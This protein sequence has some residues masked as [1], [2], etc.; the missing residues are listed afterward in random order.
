MIRPGLPD[1]LKP[2]ASLAI[3]IFAGKLPFEPNEDRVVNALAMILFGNGY[4]RVAESDG[5][6]VGFLVGNITVAGMWSNDL[7]GIEA[8][9]GIHPDHRSFRLARTF[10]HDF[11][12]WVKSMG[13]TD[14]A[15]V[16]EVSM[17]ARV[18]RFYRRLGY[19]PAEVIY[20]K[21]IE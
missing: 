6:I 18:D 3:E 8:K 4:V 9:F 2:V 12:A 10:V 15:M 19:A 21:K 17:D 1:D 20:R 7:C 13:V 16:R 11:E 14:V 5:Q